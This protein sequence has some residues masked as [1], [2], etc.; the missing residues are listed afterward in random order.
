MFDLDLNMSLFLYLVTP[1][2]IKRLYSRFS[3][4]DKENRAYL[5]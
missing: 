5:K 1:N 2:Q 3:S 4:L